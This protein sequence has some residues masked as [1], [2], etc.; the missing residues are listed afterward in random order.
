MASLR[1]QER[2]V[3]DECILLNGEEACK[4]FIEAHKACLRR[5]GFDVGVI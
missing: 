4:A 3:R 2:K 5:E 1:F